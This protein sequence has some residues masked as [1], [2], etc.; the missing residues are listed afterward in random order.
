M[1]YC[2]GAYLIPLDSV[3][4]VLLMGSLLTGS[5]GPSYQ[6]LRALI[7]RIWN[8]NGCFDYDRHSYRK[9]TLHK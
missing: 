8:C 4:M 2:A 5:L 3:L 1:T 9:L 6:I 7:S